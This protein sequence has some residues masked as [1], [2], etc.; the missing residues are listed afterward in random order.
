VALERA[1]SKPIENLRPHHLL[2]GLL[3]PEIRKEES[4]LFEEFNEETA[5][6]YVLT[7]LRG[8]YQTEIHRKIWFDRADLQVAR[9]QSFGPRGFL[10]SDTHF[11]NWQPVD[12]PGAPG[13]AASTTDAAAAGAQQ[14]P[15][16]IRIERPHDD[17]RLDLQITKVTL[18]EEIPAE[19]FTLQQ[20]AG[21]EVIHVGD[22]SE[23]KQP[24]PDTKP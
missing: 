9:L 7:V 1:S 24:K 4:V 21:A 8:G 13:A 10:I 16:A 6:Y 20:P 19:R 17:Y 18:N 11:A 23:D 3:W 22:A 14:F 15:R 5:R 12:V 2:D